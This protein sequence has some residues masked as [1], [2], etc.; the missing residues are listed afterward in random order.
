[1]TNP[2]QTPEPTEQKPWFETRVGDWE[3]T[4]SVAWLWGVAVL[5]VNVFSEVGKNKG[6][7]LFRSLTDGTPAEGIFGVL[8]ASLSI[9]VLATLPA[10]VIGSLHKTAAKSVSPSGRSALAAV[11]YLAALIGT[12]IFWA[13]LFKFAI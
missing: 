6:Q 10:M 3:R 1:M 2:Y 12:T 5:C 11:G 4:A 9:A 13:L 8:L 7:T